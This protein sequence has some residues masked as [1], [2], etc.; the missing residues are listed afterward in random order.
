MNVAREGKTLKTQICSTLA[1]LFVASSA[2]AADYTVLQRY[3]GVLEAREFDQFITVQD[4]AARRRRTIDLPKVEAELD[5]R[6]NPISKFELEVEFEHGGTG[7][8]VEYES[9]EFGEFETEIEKGGEVMIEEAYYQRSLTPR[10]NLLVGITP[11][12]FSF[13][14]I[15][16]K[17]LMFSGT[18][19]F[20]LEANIIPLEWTEPGVQLHQRFGDFT[21]R[22]GLVAG[23]NSEFFR[24][25]N[26]VGGGHQR[27]FE[28]TNFDDPAYI[29]S[30]EW[31]DVAFGRGLALSYYT[32]G[33]TKN[34]H[35]LDRVTKSGDITL[36]SAMGNW[37]V[38]RIGLKGQLIHGKLEDS[39]EISSANLHLPTNTPAY[40]GD[41]S[42]VGAK[43][44]LESLE[45]NYEFIDT[46]TAFGRWEH[47]NSFS[48]TDGTIFS[49]GRFDVRQAGWGVTHSWDDTCALK[50][51]Y[52]R[53][54]TELVGMPVTS[55]YVVQFAFDTG[56][57]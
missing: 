43:A 45:L 17:P 4:L 31:G 36:W 9:E 42:S 13:S 21:A 48:G 56:S 50:F 33:T 28:Q 19:P 53:E 52:Y 51:E 41:F 3:S 39:A 32:G 25:Y 2:W 5:V 35:K 6:I 30:L 44:Q 27:H 46:W 57:F 8:A 26:W 23:L 11:V 12:Y 47:V 14:S 29:G 22:I 15:Q 34:R 20:Y 55:T 16:R 18:Q 1:C 40:P 7:S 10:T 37:R 54:K 38:W 49:S 24:S